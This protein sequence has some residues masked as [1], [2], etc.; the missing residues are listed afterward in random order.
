MNHSLAPL[1]FALALP[2]AAQATTT[3][4][5]NLQAV[6]G[7]ISVP[8]GELVFSG[9]FGPIPTGNFF[10]LTQI[11][12]S[13][14]AV[15]RTITALW[16]R[17]P[18]SGQGA[19]GGSGNIA[20]RMAHANY[21]LVDGSTQNVDAVRTSPWVDVFVLK[22]VT[23]PVWNQPATPPPAAF[24]FQ[25]PFDV[26][27]AFNGQEA[28][29]I[30]ATLTAPVINIDGTDRSR[31]TTS[32]QDYGVGLGCVLTSGEMSVNASW[33]VWTDT[34]LGISFQVST[35][36]GSGAVPSMVVAGLGFSPTN[37]PIPGVCAPLLTS[38]EIPLYLTNLFGFGTV[39]GRSVQIPY[40]PSLVGQYDLYVQAWARR[41][42][43]PL[44]VGSRGTRPGP[45]PAPRADGFPAAMFTDNEPGSAFQVQG[46]FSKNVAAIL[47]LQ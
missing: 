26:P 21:A 20:I 33:T 16:L 18:T 40:T 14:P 25:L 24:D 13:Q 23:L 11:D 5:A 1:V 8:I 43:Q 47:G 34:S 45:I 37:L 35:N 22:P 12:A 44:F 29:L 28:L 39:Y 38:G 17:R 7:D 42:N 15:P 32:P 3:S 2:I 41:N 30:Q 4:P 46:V 9:P 36:P 27:F 6:A 10:K 31:V 19:N